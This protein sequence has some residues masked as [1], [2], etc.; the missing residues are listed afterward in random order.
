[1]DSR[2]V[3]RALVCSSA[4]LL[5]APVFS[6][7]AASAP[8]TSTKEAL[9]SVRGVAGDVELTAKVVEL[10]RTRRTAALRKTNGEVVT[11]EFSED[12]KSYSLINVGDDIKLRYSAAVVADIQPGSKSGISER[13]ESSS[14]ATN[15]AGAPPAVAGKRTV[16]VLAVI[17]S[18]DT[19]NRKATLRG[20]KR[21]V[22]VDVPAH[23]DMKKLKVGDE[24]RATV[25]ESAV[26]SVE[27]Q[28][29]TKK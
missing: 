23:I 4:L 2:D 24:V 6:Q 10:D 1:M 5:A 13:V 8:T 29:G 18:L 7:T 11:V 16:D 28:S 15:P 14:T 26:L 9:S 17:K 20:A 3:Y 25:V 27:A 12:I 21:T 22:T 19:K